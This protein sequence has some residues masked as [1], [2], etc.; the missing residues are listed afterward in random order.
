MSRIAVRRGL[1]MGTIKEVA[2]EGMKVQRQIYMARNRAR[3]CTCAQL[4]FRE[5]VESEQG[6]A[7]VA[8]LV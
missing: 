3:T 8:S 4:R 7:L 6:R 2:V 1:E 5:F